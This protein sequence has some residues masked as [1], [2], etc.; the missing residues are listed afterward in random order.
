MRARPFL[1]SNS[2]RSLRSRRSN[3]PVLNFARK[4]NRPTSRSSQTCEGLIENFEQENTPCFVN[5]H[6]RREADRLSPQ[7][8]LFESQPHLLTR[9]HHLRALRLGRLFGHIISTSSMPSIEPLPRTSPMMLCF[10]FSRLSPAEMCFPI[11]SEFA[12]NF[13]RSITCKARGPLRANHRIAAEGV[14]VNALR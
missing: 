7:S 9:F 12:C 8:A 14:E 6:R 2:T 11:L 4:A 5:A 10:S 13:S 1:T 3:T